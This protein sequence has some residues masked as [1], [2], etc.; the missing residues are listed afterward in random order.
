MNVNKRIQPSIINTV[1]WLL[2][3]MTTCVMAQS[4]KPNVVVLLVDDLGS[5]EICSYASTFHKTPSIDAL[6]AR[7]IKFTTV[8]SAAGLCSASRGALMTG[9]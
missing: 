4:R 7:G 5:G 3:A 8:Y 9:R 2:C 6:V 1:T